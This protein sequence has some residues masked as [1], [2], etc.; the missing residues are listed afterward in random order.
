MI[1]KSNPITVDDLK[2][3]FELQHSEELFGIEAE[4][5]TQ[6]TRIDSFIHD[7]SDIIDHTERLKNL[8]DPDDN[9]NNI[10]KPYI[11]RE[12][13]IIKL[14]QE[15]LKNGFEELRTACEKLRKRGNEWEHLARNMFPEIP[16]NKRFIDKKYSKRKTQQ[17]EINY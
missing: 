4:I 11:D 3:K 16:D 7:I 17:D 2:E 9:L 13:E 8:L 5:P 6:C 14:Y 10:N 1:R 12:I 15:S